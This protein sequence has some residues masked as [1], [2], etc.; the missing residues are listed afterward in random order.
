MIE[1]GQKGISRLSV[2]P[3]RKSGADTAEMVTQLLFGDHYKVLEVS[4]NGK[5]IKIK[6][7][8]D[9]YEGWI[10]VKQFHAITDE[11]FDQIN[12]SDYKIC[13]DLTASILYQKSLLPVT[14][15]SIIPINTNEIFKIEEHL[16][17][18]GEAKSL[19]AR[20]DF[21]YCKSIGM[22]YLNAPYMWGGKSP[23]GIDCS[24]YTQIVFRICGYHLFRDAS[25]QVSQGKSVDSLENSKPGDLAFFRN[26]ERKVVHVGILLENQTILH[27]SGKVKIELIDENGIFNIE[28]K[29]YTHYLTDIRRILA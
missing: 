11:Y 28:Q 10:D 7:H 17:F 2:I 1:E 6:I 23:F 29:S 16:G 3:V 19:S 13:T 8:F 27:A 26:E 4:E 5:W 21:E 20:R 18:N 22:K 9:G 25:E 15:G 12:H 24:G 14:I